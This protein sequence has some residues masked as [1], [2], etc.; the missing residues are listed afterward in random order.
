MTENAFIGFPQAP[1]EEELASAL[2]GALSTWKQLLEVLRGDFGLQ[3]TD[4]HS[5]S[6]KAGWALRVKK[7]E[8]NIVYLSPCAGLFKASFALGDKAMTAARA[9]RL[10]KAVLA[11][12]DTARRYAEGTGVALEIRKSAELASV[13]KLVAAK[14]AN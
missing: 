4:W 3:T 8:R 2:G 11:I 13:K 12:L 9:S 10:P 1:S 5:Y 14:L 6:R 7:G